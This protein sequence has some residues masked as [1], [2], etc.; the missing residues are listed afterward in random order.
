M[1]YIHSLSGRSMGSLLVTG[2]EMVGPD[3]R[4]V[5]SSG[6]VAGLEA[7]RVWGSRGAWP[8]PEVWFASLDLGERFQ[9]PW[10]P[11]IFSRPG[12]QFS[13]WNDRCLGFSSIT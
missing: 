12:S 9:G 11:L 3:G 1:I 5:E 10:I 4:A 13:A 2:R 8:F 6:H 7:D